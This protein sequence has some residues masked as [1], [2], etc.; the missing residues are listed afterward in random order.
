MSDPVL[1]QL[2]TESL[3]GFTLT[4]SFLMHCR[5]AQSSIFYVS[6]WPIAKVIIGNTLLPC[7]DGAIWE[8]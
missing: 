2:I 4:N 6:P 8:T 1:F 7:F 3:T 5:G